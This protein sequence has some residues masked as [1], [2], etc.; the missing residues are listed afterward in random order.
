MFL[1]L[2]FVCFDTVFIGDITVPIS[3]FAY[4]PPCVDYCESAPLA[5]AIWKYSLVWHDNVE[6]LGVTLTTL[7]SGSNDIVSV[8]YADDFNVTVHMNSVF[9]V[10]KLLSP[11]VTLDRFKFGLSSRKCREVL[12][13]KMMARGSSRIWKLFTL[14]H[15]G[16]GTNGPKFP[17]CSV[18]DFK[19]GSR[20]SYGKQPAWQ[21]IFSAE[22]DN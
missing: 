7:E 4:C 6:K 18:I 14:A 1:L 16:N 17:C 9:G 11:D 8:V 2:F 20:P 3:L 12:L 15:D 5:G 13:M 10:L 21:S 19:F 22:V